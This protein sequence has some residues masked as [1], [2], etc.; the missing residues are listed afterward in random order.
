MLRVFKRNE[1]LLFTLV[2]YSLLLLLVLGFLAVRLTKVTLARSAQ[3]PAAL[4]VS[5]AAIVPGVSQEVTVQGRGT[6]FGPWT[7]VEA[8]TLGVYVSGIR[9][10]SAEAMSFQI[11]HVERPGLREGERV[12]LRIHSPIEGTAKEAVSLELSITHEAEPLEL[13]LFS[14]KGERELETERDYVVFGYRVKGFSPFSLEVLEVESGE[15]YLQETERSIEHLGVPLREGLNEF[16]VTLT[17][18]LGRSVQESVRVRRRL[19]LPAGQLFTAAGAAHLALTGG[20]YTGKPIQWNS[21]P[22][23][24]IPASDCSLG[25]GPFTCGGDCGAACG[26]RCLGNRGG[27]KAPKSLRPPGSDGPVEPPPNDYLTSSGAAVRAADGVLLHNGQ[28][29]EDVVDLYIP[30]RGLDFVWSRSYQAG[31][32]LDG[33]LGRNWDYSFAAQFIV[34]SVTN[35]TQGKFS[36]GDGRRDTYSG[37]SSQGSDFVF[38]THPQGFYDISTKLLSFTSEV[39]QIKRNGF[40]QLFDASTGLLKSRQDRYGNT[41]TVIYDYTGRLSQVKDTLN[42]T[43]DFYFGTTGSADGRLTKVRDFASREVLYEYDSQA[44]YNTAHAS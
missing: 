5:P 30:G 25:N 42:R 22:T 24:Q 40:K 7:T 38:G 2:A 32:N 17:D 39:E 14:F 43:I 16:Q 13:E 41:I 4:A 9:F 1:E 37:V 36:R 6:H 11:H 29:R 31:L 35:P 44:G 3:D 23:E 19:E 26:A 10:V 33:Y 18:A 21:D 28:F 27:D 34:D 15:R 20:T 12:A 8:E